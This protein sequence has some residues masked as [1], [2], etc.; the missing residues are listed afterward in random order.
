MKRKFQ[1]SFNGFHIDSSAGVHHKH[2]GEIKLQA[3]ELAVLV[4]LILNGGRLV[5]KADLIK[6]VWGDSS[7][8]RFRHCALHFR[9]QITT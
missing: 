7:I 2:A 9:H 8:F 4:E 1:A 3:K 6:S 5:T